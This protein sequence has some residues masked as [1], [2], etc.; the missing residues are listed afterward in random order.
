M[1]P[2]LLSEGLAQWLCV[3]III[4]VHEF[5]HAWMANRCGDD[6]ARLL[7]RITLNPIAHMDLIGTVI[8]P[9][10]SVMLQS[11]G[12]GAI[13]GFIIGWGKPVPFN[14]NNL[15]R[16]GLD[17]MLIAMAGPA[18]NVILTVVVMVFLR[19][20]HFFEQ[21]GASGFSAT[22]SQAAILMA[23]I[24][25]ALCFFNL[26]PIPPLDGS[27]VMRYVTGMSYET[28][29]NLSRYGFFVVII[30]IQ[31]DAVRR[32][33]SALTIGSVELIAVALRF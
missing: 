23:T 12:A 31:I 24:S 13:A 20:V 26:L 18:M 25:M 15:R 11:S 10:L 32:L 28:Y 1:N 30:V 19:G 21:P 2:Q 33:L 14:P 3:V 9:L 17:D 7:G 5:G 4:T 22:I 6:T 27:H 8:L 16:R 29:A